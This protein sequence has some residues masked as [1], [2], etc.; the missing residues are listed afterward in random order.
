VG[1]LT[2]EIVTSWDEISQVMKRGK[3]NISFTRYGCHFT[4]FL[5]ERR[6][7]EKTNMNEYSSR[8]HTIFRMVIES[9]NR[10]SVSLDGNLRNSVNRSDDEGSV[11]VSILQLVDLAGSERVRSTGA[12]GMR[13][14]EGSHI[15]KSL[16]VLG[17]V[18]SKLSEAQTMTMTLGHPNSDSSMVHIPFRDSKLTR[19]L[20]PALGGNSKTL[21]ICTLSP[22]SLYFEES[23]STLKFAARARTIQ[24]KP[25]VNKVNY[26]FS[27]TP[28]F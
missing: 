28:L 7:I 25:K 22:S 14:K 4:S 1:H 10:E 9:R 3:G 12:E 27:S 13:L 11:K 8:S 24:N 19:I 20:Q 23:Q 6:K 5:I 26:T 15:N 21:I 17:T 2:E 16:L 18:I